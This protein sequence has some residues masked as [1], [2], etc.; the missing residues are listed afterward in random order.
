MGA[1]GGGG[2]LTS[3]SLPL[4]PLTV[5]SVLAAGRKLANIPTIPGST[6]CLNGQIM[7]DSHFMIKIFYGR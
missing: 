5:F 6:F 1:R 3:C 2:C 4:L 7:T